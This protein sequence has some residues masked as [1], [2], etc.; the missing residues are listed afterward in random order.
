M[1]TNTGSLGGFWCMLKNI[2]GLLASV[3][4]K[5][6]L[7]RKEEK[8]EEE[9]MNEKI[10]I[11]IYKGLPMVLEKIKTVA[12]AAVIGKSEAWVRQKLTQRDMRGFVQGFKEVDIDLINNGLQMLGEE[13]SQCMV[14]FDD[15]REG[16]IEQIRVL[17]NYISMPYIYN[18]V[19]GKPR[20]WYASRMLARVPG[21]KVSTFKEDDI[22]KINMS[23]M[24]IANELR[25]IEF[26]I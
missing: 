10:Q 18:K 13:I 23:A 14:K 16:V 5:I 2:G 15:D 26:T 4:K 12:F 6:Y 24:Q 17:S 3:R 8:K 22:L 1:C 7:C 25:S 11:N 9:S 20:L 19:M 21:R